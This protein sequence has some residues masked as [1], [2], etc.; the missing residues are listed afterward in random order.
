M[1]ASYLTADSDSLHMD[2][3]SHYMDVSLIPMDVS[4]C[5]TDAGLHSSCVSPH[6]ANMD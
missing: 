6:D 2:V 1:N 5:H 3:I 4:S